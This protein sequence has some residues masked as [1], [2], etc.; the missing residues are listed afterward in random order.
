LRVEA[1]GANE[2]LCGL[3]AAGPGR[4]GCGDLEGLGPGDWEAVLRQAVVHR[5]APLLYGCLRLRPCDG[6][7]PGEAAERLRTIYLVHLGRNTRRLHRLG[8]LLRTLEQAGIRVAV[9]KGVHLAEAVYRNIGLRSMND[10]DILVR[11]TDLDR[12]MQ[13]IGEAGLL[14]RANR[15]PLDVHTSISQS[16][17]GLKISTEDL[18]DRARPVVVAGTQALG[19]CPEDLLLHLVLHLSVTDLYRV[20][21]LRG[22]CDIRET[23]RRHGRDLDWG[24]VARRAAG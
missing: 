9:L 12:T 11:K 16:I 23:L 20:P 10:L 8:G 14:S 3:L 4:Q 1:A 24:R 18:L 19:L 22:L 21:G 6:E 7:V 2:R 5:V 17:A 15:F 13:C